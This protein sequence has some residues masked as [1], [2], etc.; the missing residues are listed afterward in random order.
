MKVRVDGTMSDPMEI[1][2]GVPQGSV[3]SPLLFLVMMTDFP[4]PNKFSDSLIFADDIV[5]LCRARSNRSGKIIL[6]PYMNTVAKWAA[7]WRL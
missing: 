3:L 5:I 1:T 2:I 7:K 4:A 6:Q